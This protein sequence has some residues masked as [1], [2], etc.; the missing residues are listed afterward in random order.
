MIVYN[1]TTNVS[2]AIH[3]DWLLWLKQ[4]HIPEMLE[5]KCFYESRVL[6]LLDV[7]DEEGPTYAIQLHASSSAD[8]QM[9]VEKY[10]ASIRRRSNERWSDQIIAFTSV[11]EVLH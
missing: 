6:R 4:E 9:F 3:D 1:I 11:M 8:Y 10:A 7:D 2:W 5:T